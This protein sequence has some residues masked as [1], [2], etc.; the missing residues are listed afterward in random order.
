MDEDKKEKAGKR[1]IHA[2]L[3]A[4]GASYKKAKDRRWAEEDKAGLDS[5]RLRRRTASAKRAKDPT[6]TEVHAHM[7][8]KEAQAGHKDRK[9][10]A[11]K[12]KSDGK[13]KD[14]RSYFK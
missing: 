3:Q 2:E 6:N 4:K 11:E 13:I 8:E 14:I 5:A 12:M 10:A 7:K 9:K 1:S